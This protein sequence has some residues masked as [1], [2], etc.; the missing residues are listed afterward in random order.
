GY[1]KKDKRL[2]IASTPNQDPLLH[3]TPLLG[4]DVWEHAYY[5]QYKNVRPDYLKAIWNV[6]NW[7]TVSQR[8]NK[9]Q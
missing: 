4:V 6:I 3:L 9:A 2:E 7:E 8:F 1:N 5:L